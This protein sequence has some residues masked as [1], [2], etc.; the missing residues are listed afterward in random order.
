MTRAALP[1]SSPSLTAGSPAPD[2]ELWFAALERRLTAEAQSQR[3]TI[4]ER[5]TVLFDPS[6]ALCR[7]ARAWMLG[8]PT[9]VELEFLPANSADANHRYG[10]LPWLGDELVVVSNHGQ[11]W[12]GPA[13]FIT[14]L[15]ALVEWRPWSYRLAGSFSGLAERF[16]LTISKNRKV[17]SG[18]IEHE[19]ED[20]HCR[21][22][23]SR[24][25]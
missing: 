19:C 9:Y 17:L 21:I 25:R 7:R 18:M 24:A 22:G 6:C 15:W 1:V 16:F 2:N 3:P 14:C 23:A 10:A 5:L 8:Q 11:V 13:A 4:P 20:G 12:V